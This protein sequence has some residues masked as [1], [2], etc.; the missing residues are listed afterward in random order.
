MGVVYKARQL[1]LGRLVALKI[2]LSK[3]RSSP[4]DLVRF[5]AEAEMVARL[6]HP[7]IVPIHELGQCDGRPYFTMEYVAGGT[8]AQRLARG[9]VPARQAAEILEAVARAVH[10]AHGHK[11]VH[12]DLKPANILLSFSREPPAGADSALAGGSR[13]NDVVPKITDFGLAK[14]LEEGAGLT[15]TGE[16]LGTPN[17]MAPEQALGQTEEVGP[18]TDVY[19]LGTILYELLTGRPP[20]QAKTLLS[21]LEQV[22]YDEPV[23]PRKLRLQIPR[24][25]EIICLKCLRKEPG[26]RYASALELAEDL[27]RFL[28]GEP[29]RARP[30]T[31][32]G[33]AVRWTKRHPAAAALAA[34]GAA[35]A[36]ALAAPLRDSGRLLLM[37]AGLAVAALANSLRW[38]AIVREIEQQRD[39]ALQAKAKVGLTPLPCGEKLPGSV[40]CPGL[41]MGSA[42]GEP[43]PVPSPPV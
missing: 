21:I 29:I 42:E 32:W 8:L 18:L 20:F 11:I 30:A 17:Y 10:H 40:T 24:D 5:L 43:Q 15:E 26:R 33:R 13:L 41:S 6:Q 37:T 25:L 1:R 16:V 31:L 27:R 38:R 28:A 4:A 35:A 22:A 19:A 36:L 3:A 34:V 7:H 12:R 23:P 9:S 39:A 2:I 14:R